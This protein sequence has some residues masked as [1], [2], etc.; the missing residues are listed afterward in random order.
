MMSIVFYPRSLEKSSE[1]RRDAHDELDEADQQG[2]AECESSDE[3]QPFQS[4]SAV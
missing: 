3:R 1:L 4:E 2:E